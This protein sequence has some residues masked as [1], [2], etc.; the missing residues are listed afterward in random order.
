MGHQILTFGVANPPLTI[1][2][3][4]GGFPSDIVI[5]PHFGGLVK[6]FFRSF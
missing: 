2:S 5:V 6:G 1:C 4:E 3:F